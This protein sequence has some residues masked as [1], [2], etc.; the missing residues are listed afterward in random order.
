MIWIVRNANK[1]VVKSL[2]PE[3][4]VGDIGSENVCDTLKY[5]APS[6]LYQ[7]GPFLDSPELVARLWEE[8][9][10]LEA[11]PTSNITLSKEYAKLHERLE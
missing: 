10:H 4:Q 5:F 3:N 7:G 11:C 6:R 8:S 1:K 9:I 2:Y